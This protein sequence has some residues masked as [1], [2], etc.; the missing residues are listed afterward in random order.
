M[1]QLSPHAS[2]REKAA[3]CNEEPVH[4][5]EISCELQLEPNTAKNKMNIKKQ[6]TMEEMVQ[7][8]KLKMPLQEVGNVELKPER[9]GLKM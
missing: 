9:S 3:R 8:I 4:H 5:K 2:T 7:D 6:H 1:G